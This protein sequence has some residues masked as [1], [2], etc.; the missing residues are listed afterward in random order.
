MGLY[1]SPLM[2][3]VAGSAPAA[4][5]AVR[6]QAATQTQA[7]VTV[8][9]EAE[10]G[11]TDQAETVEAPGAA[12]AVLARW[13]GLHLLDRRL[14]VAVAAQPVARLETARVVRLS[15]RTREV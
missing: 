1:Q 14:V 10:R 12:L 4:D 8:L 3:A 2:V 13:A 11:R 5:W 7:A 6:Q 15:L 9:L